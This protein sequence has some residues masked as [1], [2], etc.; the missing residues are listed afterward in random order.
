NS[1]Q[2]NDGSTQSVEGAKAAL[3]P[4]RAGEVRAPGHLRVARGRDGSKPDALEANGDRPL[5]GTS[6]VSVFSAHRSAVAQ[7][8]NLLYRR[9]VIGR[10]FESSGCTASCRRA[11]EYNSAIQHSAAKPHPKERG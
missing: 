9:F 3:H 1:R 7:T 6:R 11:A 5:I 10:S 4:R 2:E 8:C